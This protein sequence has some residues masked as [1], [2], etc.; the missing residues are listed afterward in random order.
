MPSLPEQILCRQEQNILAWDIKNEKQPPVHAD[1]LY[2]K[3]KSAI[4]FGLF[5]FKLLSAFPVEL[6]ESRQK[7]PDSRQGPAAEIS[8][9]PGTT[10]I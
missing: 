5:F 1:Y 6:M 7:S 9:H 8:D 2:I 10:I 3:T 4:I